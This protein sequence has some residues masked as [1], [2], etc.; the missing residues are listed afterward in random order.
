MAPGLLLQRI[1]TEHFLK[2]R[3]FGRETHPHPP[4]TRPMQGVPLSAGTVTTVDD[5]GAGTVVFVHDGGNILHTPL[6]RY[7]CIATQSIGTVYRS[8][9]AGD[10]NIITFFANGTYIVA[11]PGPDLTGTYTVV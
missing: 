8:Q 10:D 6:G 2:I 5:Q 7:D 9:I 11:V 1:Y 4:E 3:D